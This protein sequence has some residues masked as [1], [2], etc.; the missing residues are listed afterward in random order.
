MHATVALTCDAEAAGGDSRRPA[1]AACGRRRS[2]TPAGSPRLAVRV[3]RHAHL[4][5]PLVTEIYWGALV[6]DVGELN[7]RRRCCRQPTRRS[8]SASSMADQRA[9]D[10]RGALARRVCPA[11][12]RSCRSRAGTTSASTAS[13]IPT[14][15]PRSRCRSRS[16]SSACA[17]R[18]T[19][20]SPPARRRCRS[21]LG[22]ALGGAAGRRPAAASAGPSSRGRSNA[23][24]TTIS[25][26]STSTTSMTSTTSTTSTP[27]RPDTTVPDCHQFG[28]SYTSA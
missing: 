16:R 5:E 28:R 24:R 21:S 20:S 11:S 19:S 18:S 7:V 22:D 8:T 23:S 10:R 1:R 14:A 15:R 3:A 26:R 17:T 4:P 12:R 6:H 25:R 27:S 13:A 2:R 9:H